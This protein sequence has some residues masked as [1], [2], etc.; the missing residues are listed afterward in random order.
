MDDY[1][2][3]PGFEGYLV[4]ETGD[5]YSLPKN[6]KYGHRNHHGM[7]LKKTLWRGHYIV[8]VAKTH[9]L[10]HRLVALTFIPNT[11]NKPCVNHLDGNKT[12]NHVSNLE[13]CTIRENNIH[14]IKNG[15]IN[16]KTDKKIASSIFWGKKNQHHTLKATRKFTMEQVEQI[17]T[18]H[19]RLG[20]FA[21]VGKMFNCSAKTIEKI[22]NNKSYQITA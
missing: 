13:W 16:N 2:E 21:Q 20:V 11:E 10:V 12:N 6:G 5:V 22:I 4:N 9:Q 7:F 17:K 19:Q 18:A 14:A 3:I 1:K 8:R 15:L